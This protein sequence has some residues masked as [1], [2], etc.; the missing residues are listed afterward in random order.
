VLVTQGDT[1]YISEADAVCTRSAEARIRYLQ[2]LR[3][4]HE[5]GQG[6]PPPVHPLLQTGEHS[7]TSAGAQSTSESGADGVVVDGRL[8]VLTHSSSDSA[9]EVAAGAQGAGGEGRPAATGDAA[10]AS[11]DNSGEQQTGGHVGLECSQA[12]P[13]EPSQPLQS[14]V[15]ADV[16]T[17]ALEPSPASVPFFD[18][19]LRP[20]PK[21]APAWTT[22]LLVLIPLRLGIN[23]VNTEYH[24]VRWLFSPCE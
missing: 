6:S 8:S 15:T 5:A 23:T 4:K 2:K 7:S 19:L 22:A 3:G 21:Q 14:T 12:A 17:C 16:H 20:P 18:P 13:R 11:A 9:G 1:V 24:E 10:A